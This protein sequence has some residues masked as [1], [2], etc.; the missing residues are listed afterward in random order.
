MSAGAGICCCVRCQHSAY[1]CR[2]DMRSLLI[3]VHNRHELRDQGQH[4]SGFRT[5]AEGEAASEKNTV[6]FKLAAAC[7]KGPDGKVVN[8][9]GTWA[10]HTPCMN[11]YFCLPALQP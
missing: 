10:H 7:K 6:V 5:R 4:L 8:Q 2:P 1:A 11:K 9:K 3:N